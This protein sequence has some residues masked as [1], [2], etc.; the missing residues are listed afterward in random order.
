MADLEK[1]KGRPENHS[2]DGCGG[3]SGHWPIG[4]LIQNQLAQS[5]VQAMIS[6][7]W[8]INVGVGRRGTP[9]VSIFTPCQTNSAKQL[10][11]FIHK[12]TQ[13]NSKCSFLKPSET[14]KHLQFLLY[15][16]AKPL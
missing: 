13:H 6:A 7:A 5:H 9:Q 8:L 1:C 16:Q 14:S 15:S 11:A 2:D 4:K 3:K 10:E 12:S